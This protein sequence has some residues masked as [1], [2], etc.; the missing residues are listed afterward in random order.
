MAQDQ[1]LPETETKA[2]LIRIDE[3]SAGYVD[4]DIERLPSGGRSLWFDDEAIDRLER[5]AAIFS[6]SGLLPERYRGKKEDCAIV[7]EMAWRHGAD[8]MVFFQGVYVVHGNPGMEAKLAIALANSSGKFAQRIQYEMIGNE[9]TPSWGCKAWAEDAVTGQM[10]HATV[11]MKMAHAEGWVAKN[12]SKWK[13]IPAM[14]LKYRAAIFLLRLY[15]PEILY[16]MQ[17]TDE[18]ADIAATSVRTPETAEQA[19]KKDAL[20]EKLAKGRTGKQAPAPAPK[21]E[22]KSAPKPA[23]KQPQAEPPLEDGE[24]LDE[25]T[26]EIVDDD[27]DPFEP[28]DAEPEPAEEPEESMGKLRIRYIELCEAADE[29]PG[30]ISAM[31][32]EKLLARIDELMAK[33]RG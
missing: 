14:M 28:A 23:P 29:K 21:P 22:P 3:T 20:K 27:H 26:G 5:V 24:S 13:T 12:G 4:V 2:D 8:P 17:T 31:S 25:S 16:G 6:R 19:R 33:L 11:T 30:A 32:R 18:L 1:D 9:G 7:L 10:C 15:A